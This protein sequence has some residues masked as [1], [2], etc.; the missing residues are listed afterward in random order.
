MNINMKRVLLLF[1]M[2]QS[3]IVHASASDTPEEKPDKDAAR[4]KALSSSSI[5]VGCTGN[6]MYITGPLGDLMRGPEFLRKESADFKK[7]I[8]EKLR[9]HPTGKKLS[10][11]ELDDFRQGYG[12]ELQKESKGILHDHPGATL[13]IAPGRKGLKHAHFTLDWLRYRG[14]SKR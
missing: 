5:T 1:V 9:K 8:E 14:D 7:D 13:D 12:K 2:I 4:H 10:A 6:P 3:L 11:I